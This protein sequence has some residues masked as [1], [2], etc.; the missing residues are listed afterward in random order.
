MPNYYGQFAP[1][2]DKLIEE[3]LPINFVGTCVE[4]GAAQGVAASNTLHF[5]ELGW[6]CLCIE[7]NNDLY[8]QLRNNRKLTQ[9]YAV[10][11]TN[12]TGA[13]FA[14]VELINGDVTAI[15]GLNIDQE[16]FQQHPVRAVHEIIVDIKTLDNCLKDANI[17][18]TDFISID[19]EGTELSVLYGFSIENYQP[20]LIVIE[21]NYNTNKFD[22]YLKT[23]GYTRKLRQ[24]VNN[25]YVNK[26]YYPHE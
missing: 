8:S 21:D 10:G 6:K 17:K 5:E 25:F 9:H 13:R 22:D 3:L 11:A 26:L 18:H 14:V 19:T 23:F 15:S 20:Y 7:P 2:T 4:V 24:G 1:P 16:L 12:V